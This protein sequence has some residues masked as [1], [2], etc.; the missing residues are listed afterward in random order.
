MLDC[1]IW[2]PDESQKVLHFNVKD[3]IN[4]TFLYIKKLH[5]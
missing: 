4:E 3:V 5:L 1:K 2:R